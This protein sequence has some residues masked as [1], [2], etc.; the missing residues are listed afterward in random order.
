MNRLDLGSVRPAPVFLTRAR[1][2]TVT[3]GEL[4]D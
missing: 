1:A 4:L 3:C 2:T